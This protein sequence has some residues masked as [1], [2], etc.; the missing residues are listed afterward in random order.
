MRSVLAFYF[1]VFATSISWAHGE[2]KPGPS[3]GHIRMPGGFH[4]E[5]TL[6]SQQEAHIFLLDMAFAN[7]TAKD[8]KVEI[9]WV[10][11]KKQIP[12]QCGVMGGNHFHCVPTK[13]YPLK[14]GELRVLAIREKA[15]GQEAVYK[16]PLPEFKSDTKK[17]NHDGH[18]SH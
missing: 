7:P 2:D 18:D 10:A 15:Q 11:G 17:S 8:S 14:K 5:L 9:K 6:D 16:L 3:G 13:K 1:F 12:F 4:I